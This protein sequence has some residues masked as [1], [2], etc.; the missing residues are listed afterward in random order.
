M[1]LNQNPNLLNA[2]KFSLFSLAS[3]GIS[4]E[5]VNPGRK[6]RYANLSGYK[7]DTNVPHPLKSGKNLNGSGKNLNGSG[8]NLTGSAKIFSGSGT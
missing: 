4:R 1:W 2:F 6:I 5:I 3:T 7:T 8:K